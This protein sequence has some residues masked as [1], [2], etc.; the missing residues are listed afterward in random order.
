[1]TTAAII[2][3]G[4][5]GGAIAQTL[6]AREA[7]NRVVLID[8]AVNAAAGKALD[9]Q[10]MGAISGFHTRLVGSGDLTDAIGSGVCVIADPFRA[11]PPE[12]N[13]EGFETI[14]SLTQMLRDAPLVFAGDRHAG[15]M[16]RA[17]RDA[18]YARQ[19]VMGSSTEAFASAIRA[20][21]ALE[22]RC[23]PGEVM[24]SILGAPPKGFV[25]PWSEATVGGYLL[26][27]VLMPVQLARVQSRVANLWPP[28]PQALGM[29]AA[30]VAESV[31]HSARR[32]V[33]VLTVLDGE[34]GVRGGVSAVPSFVGTTGIVGTRSPS[35]STRERVQLETALASGIGETGSG[36]LDW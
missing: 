21:V 7:V 17:V 24:L 32:A 14:R 23:A 3:A 16:L 15:L 27:R 13:D 30:L 12:S 25:V 9:I 6:A 2:G 4:E 8:P 26:E 34:F 18:R 22:A 19:R 1:V 35:L 36:I 29:A 11:A 31:M 28:R 20:I 33:H 5:L 10:Q